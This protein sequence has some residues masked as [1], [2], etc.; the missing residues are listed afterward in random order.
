MMKAWRVMN[1]RS[2]TIIIVLGVVFNVGTVRFSLA[3]LFTVFDPTGDASGTHDVVEISGGFDITN[4]F[5]NAKFDTETLDPGN[6]GFIFGLDI[7]EDPATGLPSSAVF[8][9]C[10]CRILCIISYTN[11]S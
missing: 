10:G 3:E 9:P 5:L 6:L 4:I 7:D 8:F 11:R 2:V 1:I